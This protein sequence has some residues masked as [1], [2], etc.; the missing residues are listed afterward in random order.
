MA[1]SR[2]DVEN[3]FMF[4]P[5]GDDQA[6]GRQ[7]EAVR[8]VVREAAHN[9]NRLLPDCDERDKAFDRLDEALM[10]ANAAI[11]RQR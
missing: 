11:A 8:H 10:W 1:L 2:H 6:R 4:H 5:I 7:H 3:R 9:L